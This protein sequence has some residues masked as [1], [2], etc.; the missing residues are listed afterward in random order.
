MDTSES[1]PER[2]L[3][4]KELADMLGVLSHPHRIRIIEE[5]RDGERDVNALQLALGIN[6]SG[7]SQHLSVLRAHRLVAERRQGR[8]VFYH[9]P[10]PKLA[11]WLLDGIDFLAGSADVT[12]HVRHAIEHVRAQWADNSVK[13]K[14]DSAAG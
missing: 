9:L 2:F 13:A 7:V 8:H 6:H 11:R 10:Q 3:V 5:L 1:M 4:S 14:P 12:D